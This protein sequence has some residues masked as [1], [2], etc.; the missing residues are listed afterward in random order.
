MVVRQLTVTRDFC[1]TMLLLYPEQ[2]L[3]GPGRD[4]D[5]IFI[6]P[7]FAA[8]FPK[9]MEDFCADAEIQRVV[10]EL[11]PHSPEIHLETNGNMAWREPILLLPDGGRVVEALA[12]D[13]HPIGVAAIMPREDDI[14]T[15]QLAGLFTGSA[16]CVND[17][18]RGHGIGKALVI[19]RFLLDEELPTWEHD[20]PA[21]SPA[22]AGLIVHVASGLADLAGFLLGK[23]DRRPEIMD[24]FKINVTLEE[25]R[26]CP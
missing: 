24:R 16:L 4:A 9:A 12:T 1:E 14:N 22:G 15:F 18:M 6:D 23:T 3:S 8:T 2:I 26:P 20:T 7:I 25:P 21:Y 13:G 19:A 10:S 11:T 5:D 17:P